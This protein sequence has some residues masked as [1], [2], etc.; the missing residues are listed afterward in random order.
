MLATLATQLRFV[1]DVQS[2]DTAG[3]EPLQAIRDETAAGIQE[4]TIGLDSL[5]DALAEEVVVGRNRRPR[6]PR[7]GVTTSTVRQEGGD[8]KHP[9]SVEDWDVLSMAEGKVGRY[10]V[11]NSSKE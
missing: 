5:K 3:V 9:N 10:F 7:S 1:R 4:R 2:V 11:V 8:K 6:R